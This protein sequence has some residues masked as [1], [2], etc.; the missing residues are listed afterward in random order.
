M[1]AFLLFACLLLT[2]TIHAQQWVGTTSSDWNTASNWNP[3]SVPTVFSN[4]TFN[5][6]SPPNTCTLTSAVTVTGFTQSAGTF[7]LGATGSL[8]VTGGGGFALSG[9]TFNTNSGTLTVV[10]G[11]WNITGGLFNG[12]TG[13]V[14]LGGQVN[15]SNPAFL[16]PGTSTVWFDGAGDQTV[17]ITFVT[18]PHIAGI[19]KM[20]VNKPGTTLRFNQAATDTAAVIDSIILMDGQIQGTAILRA[21]HNVWVQSGFDG[22]A[23]PMTLVGSNNSVV[24][25]DTIFANFQGS[26]IT[27]KKT[28]PTTTVSFIRANATDT[29]RTG[30]FNADLTIARGILNFPD[31]PPVKSRFKNINI[32]PGGTLSAPNNYFYNAGA[33][34]N[35]GGTFLHNNG[36]YVFWQPT[37]PAVTQ[38]TSH[39]ENFYNL[40]IDIAGAQFSPGAGDT[41][42]VNGNLTLKGGEIIGSNASALNVKGNVIALSTFNTPNTGQLTNIVFS[43]TTD[44]TVQ[45]A[46]GLTNIWKGSAVINKP[47]GKLILNSPWAL[48][49]GAGRSFTFTKGIV[50][51]PDTANN[52]LYFTNQCVPVGASNA[53]Y[54]DGPVRVKRWTADPFEFPIGNAG[55]YAPI[56]VSD[57]WN[58][59]DDWVLSAQYFSKA[60][61]FASNPSK[62]PTLANISKREWWPLRVVSGTIT[63][64]N[65]APYLWMSYSN[66]RSGGVT[67]A[68]KLRITKWDASVG[69]WLDRGNAQDFS[70]PGFIKSPQP[71]AVF[72]PF[73]LASTDAVANPLPVHLISFTAQVKDQ[74]NLL[75]WTADNEEDF[76]SYVIESSIDGNYFISLG[77]VK[78]VND[79]LPHSYSFNDATPASKTFY[80][81]KLLDRDGHFE[82]SNVVVVSRSVHGLAIVLSPNPGRDHFTLNIS[83]EFASTATIQLSDAQGR[84]LRK[85]QTQL[86]SGMNSFDLKT[87]TLPQGIYFIQ[88]KTNRG[89]RQT[90][91]YAVMK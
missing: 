40:I 58:A 82:Y 47:S 21:S 2:T 50:S 46:V 67:D 42:V 4:V 33:H 29:V 27:I 44:Q 18:N 68:T 86:K 13:T 1:K 45:F 22:S 23:I 11:V 89:E 83:S 80:R 91:Q 63:A 66:A 70:V 85:Q 14:H 84:L 61:Q 79:G 52:Y 75:E 8:T 37:N 69:R 71:I 12:N 48:D 51:I 78:A 17:T 49:N 88:V 60:S 6:A 77:S 76:D 30:N 20:V 53:S 36:T 43:G 39:V 65:N 72:S 9:G 81:L 41:L 59:S 3:A 73:T 35:T 54:V 26:S 24:R 32:Q 55:F 64:G 15:L 57:F 90:L 56:R 74:F 16:S 25:L 5:L 7:N 87:G 62:D 28:D 34:N 10:T 31:N 38:F 19:Y